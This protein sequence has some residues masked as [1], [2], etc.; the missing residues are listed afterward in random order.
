MDQYGSAIKDFLRNLIKPRFP[1][2]WRTLRSSWK[3]VEAKAGLRAFPRYVYYKELDTVFVAISKN[4]NTTINRM[5]LDKLGIDYDPDNYH[6]IS[7]KKNSRSISQRQFLKMDTNDTFVFTFCRNPY[8]RLASAYKNKVIEESY[9]PIMQ[10]YFGRIY[11]DMPFVEFV[12]EVC[13][14]PDWWADEHFRSQTADIYPNGIDKVDYTGRVENFAEDIQPI[15]EKFDLP[16]PQRT[17]KSSVEST[18]IAPSYDTQ[19]IVQKVYKR[20]KNDFE[21]FDYKDDYKKRTKILQ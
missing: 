4:A 17:N 9:Q 15:R 12:E 8:G 2:T 13:N 7:G 5:F 6:T 3:W 20:Y 10:N 14:I 19:A 21:N 18:N 16:K 11:P 1:K